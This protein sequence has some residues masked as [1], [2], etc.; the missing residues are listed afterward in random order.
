MHVERLWPD[1]RLRNYHYLVVCP[2]TGEALAIDP[3]DAQLVHETARRHGWQ[4]TQILNTHHHH[5]H[6][7]GNAALQAATGARVLAHAGAA[8]AVPAAHQMSN[9]AFDFRAGGPVVGLP[10]GVTLTRPGRG[11][12]GFPAA[13]GDVPAGL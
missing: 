5:D 12:V 3:F 7:A 6:V 11:Q 1:T 2:Q 4:I 8:S 9:F 13:D 10:D